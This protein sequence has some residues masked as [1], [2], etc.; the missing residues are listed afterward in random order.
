MASFVAQK[1]KNLLVMR[2]TLVQFLGWE[3]SLE[4]GIE[5][6]SSILAWRNRIDRGAWWAAVHGITKSR[7]QLGN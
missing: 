7:T 1:V 4:E 2:E 6:H 5:T 3:D